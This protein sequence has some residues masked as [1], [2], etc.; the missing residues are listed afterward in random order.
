MEEDKGA[1][2]GEG[3]EEGTAEPER[4]ELEG[5]HEQEVG[6]LISD[7]I[8]NGVIF[9]WE[10]N[11]EGE[12]TEK[13]EGIE[14]EEEHQTEYAARIHLPKH[15]EDSLVHS[16][17][18]KDKVDEGGCY[19]PPATRSIHRWGIVVDKWLNN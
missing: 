6:K 8:G 13:E 10:W 16:E 7:D 2:R 11:G 17:Q 19:N 3:L 5:E 15:E 14:E 18:Q 9:V 4:E 1:R 12:D